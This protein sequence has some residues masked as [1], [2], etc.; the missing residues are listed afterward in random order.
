MSA[1][2]AELARPETGRDEEQRAGPERA[3]AARHG[4][5]ED[6]DDRALAVG[7]DGGRAVD[8]L[9][10]QA[11]VLPVG[12]RAP[13]GRER[14]RHVAEV[15]AAQRLVDVQLARPVEVVDAVGR[16]AALLHL[17]DHRPGADGV[18]AAGGDEQGVAALDVDAVQEGARVL[19]VAQR[20][21]EPG[22]VDAAAQ[23]REEMRARPGL[24][25][26]PCLGLRLAAQRRRDR[27]RGMD[28]HRERL[29]RVE[30]LDQQREPVLVAR[31]AGRAEHRLAVVRPQVVERPALQGSLGHDALVVRAVDELPG[32]ADRRLGRQRP[33]VELLES[34]P[35][36]DALLEHRAE[37]EWGV[38]RRQCRNAG[39]T[40]GP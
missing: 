39:H 4:A 19:P 7:G 23:A 36:P 9:V 14:R 27:G 17:E 15:D 1:R 13:A 11:E 26:D 30:Q 21:L 28:L 32:L 34:A 16:V 2:A 29:A 18:D 37:G 5:V 35:A 31:R 12:D 25:D 3:R 6:A 38:E 22:P 10:A 33:A 40:A 20:R 8:A 24:R